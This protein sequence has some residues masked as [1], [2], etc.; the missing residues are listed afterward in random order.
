M[1]R[2]LS[3]AWGLGSIIGAALI[4]SA[5]AERG[6]YIA[7]LLPIIF[8]ML[9]FLAF[10]GA[11]L[12]KRASAPSK[13]LTRVGRVTIPNLTR[14][15]AAAHTVILIGHPSQYVSGRLTGSAA[16]VS[17][18]SYLEDET[19]ILGG[20]RLRSGTTTMPLDVSLGVC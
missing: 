8:L 2:V 10:A 11:A 13:Q 12:I 17:S 3:L 6:G 1:I 7:L 15:I 20:V 14:S 4:L 9:L 16:K 5:I 18:V 19:T